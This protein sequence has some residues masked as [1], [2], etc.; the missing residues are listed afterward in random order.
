M[1]IVKTRS[2]TGKNWAVYHASNGT[3]QNNVVYLNL[4]NATNSSAAQWN[5][6]APTSSVFSVAGSPASGYDDVNLASTTHVAYCFAEVAGYSAF[7]SYTGNAST[8]GPFVYT[9]FRPRWVMLKKT[10]ATDDWVVFDTA[11]D[12]FNVVNDWLFPN[13][14]NAELTSAGS[15]DVLSNGFKLRS[16]SGATNASGATFIYAAFAE[17]PAKFSLAR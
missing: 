7:G 11:R 16:T 8:D 12:T 13:L 5:T 9:G 17:T 14:S 15:P 6:T 10:S 4:T 2:A 3:P 1:I